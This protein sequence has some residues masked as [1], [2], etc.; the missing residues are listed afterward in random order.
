MFIVVFFRRTH[1]QIWTRIVAVMKLKGVHL[2]ALLPQTFCFREVMFHMLRALSP[3]SDAALTAGC[4][5][6]LLGYACVGTRRGAFL[7]AS[8]GIFSAM[9]G[10][11]L[12]AKRYEDR[13]RSLESSV[14]TLGTDLAGLDVRFSGLLEESSDTASRVGP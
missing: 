4:A 3:E 5:G 10:G 8:I 6:G 9:F 13:I 14:G 7:G 2:F 11:S 1:T 12:A